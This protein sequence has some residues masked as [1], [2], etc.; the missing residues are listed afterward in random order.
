MVFAID[1]AYKGRTIKEKI[2]KLKFFNKALFQKD[3]SVTMAVT[4]R[5]M[6]VIAEKEGDP[7][8]ANEIRNLGLE[9][10]LMRTEELTAEKAFVIGWNIWLF[11]LCCVLLVAWLFL[12]VMNT[13]RRH[14][15]GYLN[16][17]IRDD[18]GNVQ[19]HQLLNKRVV[20]IGANQCD[21]NVPTIASTLVLKGRVGS[22]F[23]LVKR[24]VMANCKCTPTS[25]DHI[26]IG[27]KL[28]KNNKFHRLKLQQTASISSLGVLNFSVGE[29]DARKSNL[30]YVIACVLFVLVTLATVAVCLFL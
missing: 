4:Y 24:R 13:L 20:T 18:N 9:N 21:I 3:V 17:L 27:G 22:P 28:K 11:S 26:S 10:D 25:T 30:T 7:S 29:R 23:S 12:F 8:F 15:L 5:P 6:F 14:R 19:T 16:L 1:S 2:G